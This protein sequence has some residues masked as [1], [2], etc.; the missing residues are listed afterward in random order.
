MPVAFAKVALSG[1]L[2]DCNES[3][4]R[5][6]GLN[7]KEQIFSINYLNNNYRSI[8]SN[9]KL[10]AQIKINKEF[11]INSVWKSFTNN[12]LNVKE[13]FKLVEKNQDKECFYYVLI[14][15][16]TE[17][18]RFIRSLEITEEKYKFLIDQIPVGIYRIITT[19]E[20]VFCNN[21]LAN[22]LGYKNSDEL[23]G[24]NAEEV[25]HYPIEYYKKRIEEINKKSTSF[26]FEF[27]ITNKEGKKLW[28][29]DA[30]KIFYDT[31]D[32]VLIYDGII[33]DISSRK[34]AEINL[35]RLIT[36]FNQI[37]EGIVVTDL[38]GRV[39]YLNPALEKM[40]GRQS[41]EL[42]GQKLNIISSGQHSRDFYRKLWNTISN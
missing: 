24:T 35:L 38:Q 28:L 4:M 25:F 37:S 11:S 7:S 42:S 23:I 31:S 12:S 5:L 20:I 19:G 18:E 3:F 32:E 29:H 33:Q 27:S 2:I 13:Y 21:Y 26:I 36:A 30:A 34:E 9:Q 1:F 15:D 41:D 10:S 6:F 22:L 14:E 40:T 8:E 39:I 16:N 17:K